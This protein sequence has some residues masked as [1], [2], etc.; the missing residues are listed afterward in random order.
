MQ[1]C[2]STPLLSE[3]SNNN[4]QQSENEDESANH[5]NL[6]D[7]HPDEHDFDNN[8]DSLVQ[9]LDHDN[10]TTAELIN[11]CPVPPTKPATAAVVVNPPVDVILDETQCCP[12][13][14]IRPRIQSDQAM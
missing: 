6:S 12:K 7:K 4:V 14:E 2:S 11:H 9:A 10:I 3:Q 5:D 1:I 8:N 13:W